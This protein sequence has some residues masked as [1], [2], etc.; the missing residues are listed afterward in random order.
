MPLCHVMLDLE[1]MSTEPNA[2]IVAIGAVRF[3]EKQVSTRVFYETISLKSCQNLG[4]HISAETVCW[5]LSKDR[6]EETIK[7]IRASSATLPA[8][9]NRFNDWLCSHSASED[10]R[11]WGNGANFD[12]VIIKSAFKAVGLPHP[13]AFYHDRCF[14]TFRSVYPP[15]STK[16][17]GINH[18]AGDD[19]RYQAQVAQFICEKNG[20]ILN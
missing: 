17:E 13:W 15:V 16:F 6:D 19:A 10:L 4:L 20:V 8:V 9:I 7:E 5:W 12:N 18:H 1:T 14:R 3:N 11:I 2:A